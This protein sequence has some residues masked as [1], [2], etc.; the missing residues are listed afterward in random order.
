VGDPEDLRREN[1]DNQRQHQPEIEVLG[2]PSYSQPDSRSFLDEQ[3]ENLGI[4]HF[5][6]FAATGGTDEIISSDTTS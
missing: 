5:S 6:G 3:L 2:V 1:I 4:V